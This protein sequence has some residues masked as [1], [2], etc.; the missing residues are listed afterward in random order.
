MCLTINRF[1]HPRLKPKTAKKDIP[2]YKLVDF[3]G[4]N[5]STPYYDIQIDQFTVIDGLKADVFHL[6]PLGLNI[7]HGI[8][9]FRTREKAEEHAEIHP[10]RAIL[11]CYIPKGSKYWVGKNKDYASDKIKF[12]HWHKHTDDGEF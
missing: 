7:H 4:K 3:C 2:C 5:V 9:T 1:Y 8:H 11:A 12:N 6:N 10:T